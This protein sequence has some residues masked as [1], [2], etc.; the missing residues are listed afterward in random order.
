MLMVHVTGTMSVSAIRIPA[1]KTAKNAVIIVHGLG[2]SGEGWSW[3]PRVIQDS[4]IFRAHEETNYIFPN[5]PSIPITVN[6]GMKMPGW[7]DI[8]QLGG[9]HPKQDVEGFL[10]SCEVI[11]GLIQEQIDQHSIPPENILLGGFSQGAALSMAVLSLLDFKIGGLLAFSGFCPVMDAIKA[12]MN[13]QGVNFSTPVF[14]GHG[15]LD[16][17]INFSFGKS[18]AEFYQGLGFQDWSFRPY[19]NLGHSTSNQELVEAVQFISRV[20]DK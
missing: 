12:R 16:P 8:Y 2:D 11:K 4:H 5:A 13:K 17:V 6:G 7:F 19:K 1:S 10:K 15:E 14:Q 9:N 20:L 18:T 3:F